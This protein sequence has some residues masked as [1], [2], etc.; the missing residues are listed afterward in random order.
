MTD[1]HSFQ[2]VGEESGARID[3]FLA[4]RLDHLSRAQIQKAITG[5][6]VY[7]NNLPAKAGQRLREGDRLVFEQPPVEAYEVEPEDIPLAVVYEDASLL[8]IDKPAG[9]VVHPAA[10][11]YRGTLVHALLFHCRDLSGIGGVMR[12][13]IVHRLDKG[14]SGLLVVAKSD[15]AHQGLAA[16]FKS[17]EVQKTYEALVYGD[18]KGD[19]GLIDE[20]VG[21]DMADRKKMSTRTRRG[22]EA[23]TY[24]RVA[25]RYGAITLLQI[26]IETGRTHQIRV[27]LHHAGHPLVGDAVYGGGIGRVKALT[28]PGLKEQIRALS[29]PALHSSRLSFVHPITGQSLDFTSPLPED[30]SAL[31]DFL[32]R[33][34]VRP[35]TGS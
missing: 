13:G 5:G 14:T 21:R 4:S 9:L 2:I 20:P 34:T 11:N 3:V 23:R 26:N 18:I 10:G 33:A 24:W 28:D 35:S 16:Q 22:K 25:E 31:C 27:H 15:A 6:H 32:R 1:T 17:H 8:V 7:L 30:I 19:E 12:P 29:R